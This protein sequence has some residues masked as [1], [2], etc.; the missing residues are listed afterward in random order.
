MTDKQPIDYARAESGD[1]V[2]KKFRR[3]VVMFVVAT[4]IAMLAGLGW[5]A[6]WHREVWLVGSAARKL[7]WHMVS[8]AGWFHV[9]GPAR[10]TWLNE[11]WPMSFWYYE[12]KTVGIV[13]TRWKDPGSPKWKVWIRYRTLFTLAMI[14]WI[15]TLIRMI[16]SWKR[17]ALLAPAPT[18]D[19]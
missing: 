10:L 4:L 18:S 2:R 16:L 17:K 5:A 19:L 13:L 1:V 14:P 12:N 15:I 3:R 7:N 9:I 6:T 8:E 11:T